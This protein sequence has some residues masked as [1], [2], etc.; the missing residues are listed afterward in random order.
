[1]IERKIIIISNILKKLIKFSSLAL[2]SL[3]GVSLVGCHSMMAGMLNPEGI[4]SAEEKKIFFDSLALM[5]IVVIPVFIMS[6]TF[7]LHYRAGK[8]TI[9]YRPNWGRSVLL[10]VI[11][12]GIPCAIILILGIMTWAMTHKL[13]PYRR[14]DVP[15]KHMLIQVVA[16][17]WKWLFIYPKQNIATVNYL[18]IAKGQQVEFWLTNDNV[19]MSAF[20]VP[21]LGSQ[22]YTMAGMRTRLHLVAKKDGTYTGLD[23]QFNGDGFSD[24]CFTVKVVEQNE[25]RD[26]FAEIKRSKQSLT[27]PV[28]ENLIQPSVNESVHYYSVVI[29]RLFSKI[30]MKYK[31]TTGIMPIQWEHRLPGC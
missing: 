3:I 2:I 20:F 18:E 30:I 7:I 27:V 21:Q 25:L 14:L 11:W 23:S 10:E 1:M 9:D 17:P 13:D 16:L 28:Y 24:M 6:F 29:P 8:S 26:W 15:G 12:W 19:P 5:L 22:I 4:V 31:Q